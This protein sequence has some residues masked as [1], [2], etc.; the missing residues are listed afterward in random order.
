[1]S[2]Q[3]NDDDP[4]LRR[5]LDSI[6]L[7]DDGSSTRRREPA[8]PGQAEAVLARILEQP[9]DVDAR[10]LSSPGRRWTSRRWATLSVGAA[11]AVCLAVALALVLLVP[12]TG[13]RPAAAQTPPM[14]TFSL[15]EGDDVLTA[16]APARDALLELAERAA[17]LSPAD[18]LPVQRIVADAW[19]TSTDPADGGKGPRTVLVP[20]RVEVYQYDDGSRRSIE[21]R[22]AALD[23]RGRVTDEPGSWTDVSPTTDDTFTNDL[24]AHYPQT[25]PATID[26]LRRQL[27]PADAC[28]ARTG[29]CLLSAVSDLF[30][31]YVVDPASTGRLW[32]LLA[33]DPTI[34]SLG[35]TTDR[36]GRRADAFVADALDET[37]RIVV[38]IDPDTGRYLGSETILVRPNPDLGFKPPAVTQF[39]AIV[40]SSRVDDAAVPDAATTVRH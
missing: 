5:L 30:G 23:S 14:L 19:W 10:P 37:Q 32:R 20:R 36:L 28:G 16:G 15:A 27:A 2:G 13:P 17:R 35:T 12:G 1:M 29:G 34:T 3:R 22:G 24:G 7:R 18:R 25:L 31:G 9:R 26:G 8:V 4:E 21:R 38:L 33:T 39:M 40:S 11:V 6:G